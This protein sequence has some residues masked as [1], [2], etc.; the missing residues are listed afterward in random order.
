VPPRTLIETVLV[1]LYAT[2]LGHENVSAA[3]GFF[4]VGGSSLQA[5]QLVTALRDLLAVDLDVSAV[6]L[7]PTAQQ[8]AAHLR[9]KYGFDDADLDDES[10]EELEQLEQSDGAVPGAKG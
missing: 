1:D 7:A 2:L 10:I 8:L 9:D 5:M 6:F 3:G 4:D